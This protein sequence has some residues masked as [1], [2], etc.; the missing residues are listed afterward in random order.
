MAIA[1]YLKVFHPSLSPYHLSIYLFFIYLCDFTRSQ[2]Q[3]VGSS[4]APCGFQCPRNQT[5]AL[6]PG[7]AV[8]AAGPPGKS[9]SFLTNHLIELDF[10]GFQPCYQEISI[11]FP[12]IFSDLFLFL[13]LLFNSLVQHFHNN[14]QQQGQSPSFIFKETLF[15]LTLFSAS[16]CSWKRWWKGRGRD[17]LGIWD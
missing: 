17:K 16:F 5:Q 11:T 6:C 13:I 7:T 4:V 15:F 12:L 2:L 14:V 10:L 9:V 3:Y 8:L 1:C